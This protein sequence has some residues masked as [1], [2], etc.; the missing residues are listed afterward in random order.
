M[1]WDASFSMRGSWSKDGSESSLG[2]QCIGRL[3]IVSGS[4]TRVLDLLD[5]FLWVGSRTATSPDLISSLAA[6]LDV[7]EHACRNLPSWSDS[8]FGDN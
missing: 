4:M 7:E 8:V 6:Q 1:Q 3:T 2:E 5:R